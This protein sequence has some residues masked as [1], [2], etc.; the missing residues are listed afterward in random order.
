MRLQI[1]VARLNGYPYPFKNFC[2]PFKRLRK[3]F[4]R[5]FWA[6]VCRSSSICF[7]PFK[8][9]CVNVRFPMEGHKYKMP[10]WTEFSIKFDGIII[11]GEPLNAKLVPCV[12]EVLAAHEQV[13]HCLLALSDSLLSSSS[14]ACAAWS[15]ALVCSSSSFSIS[16]RSFSGAQGASSLLSL[17]SVWVALLG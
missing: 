13:Q 15:C 2:W 1:S 16:W 8:R 9:L 6:F 5:P 17:S 7:W 10:I 4:K 14:S 3:A 11:C 12:F